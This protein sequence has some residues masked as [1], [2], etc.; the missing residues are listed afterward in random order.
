MRG[1]VHASLGLAIGITNS[2]LVTNELSKLNYINENNFTKIFIGGITL[3]ILGSLF[4]DIDY[5]NSILGKR[6]KP[7]SLLINKIFGHR[8]FFHSGILYFPIHIFLIIFCLLN[9]NNQSIYYI[10]SFFI[11][12]YFH[13]F[14]DSF[15]TAKTPLFYPFSKKRFKQFSKYSNNFFNFYW[16]FINNIFILFSNISFLIKALYLG[17]FLLLQKNA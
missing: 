14:Q 3:T 9:K 7:I 10:N 4:P 17:L 8:K 1:S 2:I 6:F 15:T 5:P 11:G 16:I 12:L 13:L